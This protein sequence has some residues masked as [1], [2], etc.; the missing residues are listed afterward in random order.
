MQTYLVIYSENVL[1]DLVEIIS[2]EL[3]N[4]SGN[5]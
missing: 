2:L 5:S 1:D 4:I 3:S